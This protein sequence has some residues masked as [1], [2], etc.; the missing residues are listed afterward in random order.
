MCLDLLSRDAMRADFDLARCY[1]PELSLDRA[2][3][4]VWLSRQ[5]TV[6]MADQISGPNSTTVGYWFHG[7]PEAACMRP[8]VALGWP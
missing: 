4:T 5:R 2:E 7:H 6:V 3:R 8:T 1:P